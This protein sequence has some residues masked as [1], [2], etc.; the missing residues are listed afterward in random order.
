HTGRLPASCEV[1]VIVPKGWSAIAQGEPTGKWV[2]GNQ[3]TYG[4][5]NPLPVCYLTVAAGKYTVTTRKIGGLAVSSYLLHHTPGRG[6]G[7]T[8]STRRRWE[9][10]RRCS[11][12]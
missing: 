7:C 1:R 10:W 2:S 8:S 6:Q 9:A 11:R 12:R 3:T 4:W 5:K